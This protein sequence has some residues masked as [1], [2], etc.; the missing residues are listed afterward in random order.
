[1]VIFSICELEAVKMLPPFQKTVNNLHIL[2]HLSHTCIYEQ[3]KG[4]RTCMYTMQK[5][6]YE[7]PSRTIRH[8]T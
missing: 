1:M 7:K 3:T 4:T 5:A 6:P 2:T 8:I